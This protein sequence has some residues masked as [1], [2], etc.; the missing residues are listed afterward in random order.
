MKNTKVIYTSGTWD[1]FHYGHLNI[2]K[3]AKALG[4]YLIVGVSTDKLIKSYKLCNPIISYSGRR[5]IIESI[6]CVDL[7]IK[8][9]KFFDIDQLKPY[10]I[11]I[12]VLGDDW[13]NIKFPELA[14]VVQALKCSLEFLPYTKS[15][16]SSKIK[17][18]IIKNSYNIIQSSISR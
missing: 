2:L 11:D 18:K 1:L 8:Q 13:K 7:V 3:R 12:I 15:L 4:I 10:G 5:K 14:N 16:S 9:D 6:K 17:E